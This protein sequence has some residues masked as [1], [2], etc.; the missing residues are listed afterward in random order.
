[1]SSKVTVAKIEF[2]LG[3]ETFVKNTLI[4]ATSAACIFYEN[5]KPENIVSLLDQ[6]IEIKLDFFTLNARFFKVDSGSDSYYSLRFIDLNENQKKSLQNFL[7]SVGADSPSNRKMPRLSITP[8][9][10]M[11][12]VPSYI[13]INRQ[14]E[15][16]FLSILNFNIEGML[17]QTQANDNPHLEVGDDIDF[18][19]FISD[20]DCIPNLNAKIM[21]LTEE[22]P[23]GEE[24]KVI[25]YGIKLGEMQLLSKERYKRII[26]E[27]CDLVSGSD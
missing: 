26:K 5:N 9:T 27:Y 8:E 3:D 20:G 4:S 15:T 22:I 13:I 6:T 17:V 11:M 25:Q 24:N 19:L 14:T 23:A 18:N 10:L 1:M 21:R 2:T 7:D 16:H 12:G